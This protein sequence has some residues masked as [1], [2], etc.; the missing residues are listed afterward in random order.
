MIHVGSTY[1]SS[2]P[3]T[4]S[5]L[6]DHSNRQSR[7]PVDRPYPASCLLVS[8]AVA[9][10]WPVTC[11]LLIETYGSSH[12]VFT[13]LQLYIPKVQGGLVL[14]SL[15]DKS[16]VKVTPVQG[17]V[18]P[19][20]LYLPT[21]ETSRRELLV[22]KEKETP[23]HGGRVL[24]VKKERQSRVASTLGRAENDVLPWDS[25]GQALI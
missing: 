16:V 12:L 4:S 8:G 22:I 13:L 10:G 3:T 2:T 5:R 21:Q 17:I 1:T 23:A 24:Q 25:H 19:L 14:S 7:S 9:T 18:F 6:E 15:L 20:A 11:H